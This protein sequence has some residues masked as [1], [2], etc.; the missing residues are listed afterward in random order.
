[1]V[2]GGGGRSV[3]TRVVQSFGGSG[4]LGADGGWGSSSTSVT[5]TAQNGSGNYP[6]LAQEGSNS[7]GRGGFAGG[8]R[9]GGA[10]GTGHAQSNGYQVSGGGGGEAG[11]DGVSQQL[12]WLR[13][14]L[15]Q[16]LEVEVGVVGVVG[17]EAPVD[18]HPPTSMGRTLTR[19]AGV[20]EVLALL[21]VVVVP[22]L[23]GMVGTVRLVRLQVQ[24][25]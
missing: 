10:G 13:G 8:P 24:C 23:V 12:C 11:A 15:I 4:G 1:M 16:V 3:K 9:S 20:L 21:P 14:I 19:L 5:N 7:R 25:S 18:L 2:V 6:G 17:V 22:L